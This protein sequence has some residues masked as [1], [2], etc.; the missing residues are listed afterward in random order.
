[1]RYIKAYENKSGNPF[2]K[3]LVFQNTKNQYKYPT[4][5]IIEILDYIKPPGFF[6]FKL[7]FTK[8]IL[9]GGEYTDSANYIHKDFT[10]SNMY[11]LEILYQ[12][13]SLKD[14]KNFIDFRIVSSKYNL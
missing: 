8:K 2:K 6:H 3:Y 5:D 12:T 7:I 1:M 14:A 11:H 4:Y 10:I 9:S 13:N